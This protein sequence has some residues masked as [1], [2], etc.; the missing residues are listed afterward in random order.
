MKARGCNCKYWKK[1]VKTIIS[2]LECADLL[3]KG[4]FK[5]KELTWFEFCP[6]CGSKLVESGEDIKE[7]TLDDNFVPQKTIINLVEK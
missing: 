3:S 6:W 5:T 7:Y 4:I 2:A 1:E